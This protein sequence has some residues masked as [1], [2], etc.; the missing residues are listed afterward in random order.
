MNKP[1]IEQYVLEILTPVHVGMAQEKNYLKGVDYIYENG[2]AIFINQEKIF[3]HLDEKEINNYSSMLASGNIEKIKQYFKQR[4]FLKDEFIFPHKTVSIHIPDDNEGKINRLYTD[5]LG[6]HAIPGSSLKGSIRSILFNASV[7]NIG[8]K[9]SERI[10][11]SINDNPLRHLQV[12]DCMFKE[13][14][15]TTIVPVKVYSADGIQNNP[16]GSWKDKNRA[17]HTRSFNNEKFISYYESFVPGLHS[18]V[19]ISIDP[20]KMKKQLIFID[21]KNLLSLISEHTEKYIDKEIKFYSEYNNYELSNIV[22]SMEKLKKHNRETGCCVLRVG[23][24]VGFHAITGDWMFENHLIDSID[25]RSKR[26]LQGTKN[27]AKT[28]KFAFESSDNGWKFLPM[29]YVKLYTEEAWK[30]VAAEK[31]KSIQAEKLQMEKNEQ[32]RLKAIEAEKLEEA[33]AKKPQLFKGKL[34]IDAQPIDAEVIEPGTPNI[35]KLFIENIDYHVEMRGY[36]SPIEILTIVQ[37]KIN[38]IR[39]GEI[40]QVGFIRIK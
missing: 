25:A 9:E 31:E 21:S 35:V 20:E 39:K 29:G 19:R 38:Q 6:H 4:G 17:G 12:N 28:R 27:S 10:F 8:E 33:K 16:Y 30:Q 13:G 5:G 40:K 7:N 14:N 2:Q 11:K 1:I 18:T 26:G 22:G 36:N 32:I 34:K 24:G 3:K 15:C 37:V 23:A